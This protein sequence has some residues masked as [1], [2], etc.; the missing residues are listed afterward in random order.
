MGKYGASGALKVEK[1][2]REPPRKPFREIFI[3]KK[4][5]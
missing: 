4:V 1:A 3:Q 5:A 2:F